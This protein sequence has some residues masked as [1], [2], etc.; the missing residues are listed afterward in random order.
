M[1]G[2]LCSNLRRAYDFYENCIHQKIILLPYSKLFYTSLR[3]PKRKSAAQSESSKVRYWLK[4]AYCDLRNYKISCYLHAIL[5]P[6][7]CIDIKTRSDRK[8]KIIWSLFTKTIFSKCF[9]F[10]WSFLLI[11]LY[12]LFH[13]L[14]LHVTSCVYNIYIEA[15]TRVVLYKRCSLLRTYNIFKKRL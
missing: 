5:R 4:L 9:S 6:I 8:W 11:S 13:L 3:C 7:F 14:R 2:K 1:K 12:P 15:A 10:Y